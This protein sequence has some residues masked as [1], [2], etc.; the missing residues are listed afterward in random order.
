MSEITMNTTTT[1]VRLTKKA[2]RAIKEY[3]RET[4]M[5]R[6]LLVAEAVKTVGTGRTITRHDID[7][8]F[9]TIIAEDV[10]AEPA[11][12]SPAEP[13][14]LPDLRCPAGIRD[15]LVW[16]QRRNVYL[17]EAPNKKKAASG[18]FFWIIPERTDGG[19]DD[20]TRLWADYQRTAT[21]G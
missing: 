17:I 1:L 2:Q 8:A 13:E 11:A 16:C 6:A 3:E 12:P 4:G 5:N 20:L 7:A 18:N 14:T 10:A 9:D 19:S 15:F 21:Q